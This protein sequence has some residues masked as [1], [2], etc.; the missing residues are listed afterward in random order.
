MKSIGIASVAALALVFVAAGPARANLVLNGSFQTGDFTDWT[1]SGDTVGDY[2]TRG[3]ING[4]PQQAALTTNI[5]DTGSLSQTIATTPGAQYSF[6]FILAGDGATPN[7]FSASFGGSTVLSL[8]NVGPT[9]PTGTSYS[10]TV[11]AASASSS[12][13]FTDDDPPGFLY[14]SGVSVTPLAVTVPEPASA[15]LFSVG[16]LGAM[17]V[18]RRRA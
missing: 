1:L 18:R 9:V 15:A 2:V 4:T 17:A 8:T 13:S 16:I 10:F 11:T 12:V 14:L 6:G 7:S 3:Q 5:N